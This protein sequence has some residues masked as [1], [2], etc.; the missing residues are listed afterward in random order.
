MPS[1]V[2]LDRDGVINQRIVDGYVI[3]WEQ[4][5]FAPGALDAL[6]LLNQAK[7]LPLVVSN[8]ACVG[9]GLISMAALEDITRRFV[10]EVEGHGGRIYAVYYCPHREEDRCEC[11]KPKPGLLRQA[12]REHRFTFAETFLISD[13]VADLQAAR[14]V[15]CPALLIAGGST[16]LPQDY[17]PRAI[18]PNLLAAAQLI[19]DHVA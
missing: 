6:R 17:R 15:G 5:A 3:S 11:R 4:F 19:V 18:L 7:Y 14:A 10:E 9:K 16:N 2:L 12:Q 1:F 13:S 8:Q